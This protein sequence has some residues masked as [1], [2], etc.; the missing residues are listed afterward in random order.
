MTT[1]EIEVFRLW[2]DNTWDTEFVDVPSDVDVTDELALQ[3]ACELATFSDLH[4][5][6]DLPV[7]VG[8]YHIPNDDSD[9]EAVCEGTGC[10]RHDFEA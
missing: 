5:S 8:V 9:D 3:H 4:C 2:D 6:A 1:R 10:G 7:V